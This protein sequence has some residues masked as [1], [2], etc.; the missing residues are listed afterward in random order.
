MKL[1][2]FLNGLRAATSAAELEAAI[3]A[4]FKHP[5]HGP[6]WS[7]ICNVRIAKGIEICDAHPLGKFVP[8][9]GPGRKLTVCGETYKVGRGGN[10][11]GVRYAWH[12]AGEWAMS[13]LRR[14]GFSVQAANRI[15]EGWRDYPH[16]CLAIVEKAVAGEIPD[17]ELNVLR[18]HG[19]IDGNP[20][21]Y[22][23]EQNDADKGD[24]RATRPCPCGGTLFDWG[25][26]H[27]LGFEFINWHCN[28]CP[29]IYTEYMTTAQLYALRRASRKV[30]S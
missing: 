16:R 6:T 26:G 14:E 8:R 22:T 30:P 21:R 2:D 28:A 12:Y 10:S 9:F 29:E 20:I 17:P 24:H 11:T 4:D 3:Q 15:W 23:I 18:P 25:A 7:K 27:S 19:R 5:F 1:A 13:I